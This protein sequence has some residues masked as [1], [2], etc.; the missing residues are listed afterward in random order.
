MK[1]VGADHGLAIRDAR[2]EDMSAVQTIYAHHVR[3][4]LASFEEQPP[5]VAEIIRRFEVTVGAGYPFLVAE[6]ATGPVV[7]YAYAGC[8]RSRPAY[9]HTVETSLYIA[10]EHRGQGIGRRLLEALIT[11]CEA[12]GYRQ[13]VAVIGDSGNTASIGLHESLGFTRIGTLV[14]AGFKF[15]RWVDSVY[16][17]RPLGS[18]DTAPPEPRD[19]RPDATPSPR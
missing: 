19:R 11:R 17:Q 9:R 12:L 13:M 8:Y 6:A 5:D 4:G 1:P 7:G 14:A 18:G 15:N 3:N 10:E 2:P 16:M